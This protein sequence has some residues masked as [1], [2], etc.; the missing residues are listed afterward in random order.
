MT[1]SDPHRRA[2]ISARTHASQRS[3]EP[4]SE[5]YPP[6]PE[7]KF[8]AVESGWSPTVP[9]AALQ[10][11]RQMRLLETLGFSL[12]SYL[13][14]ILLNLAIALPLAWLLN[15]WS[16]EA[17]TLDTSSR[18]IY[19]AIHQA[20]VFEEQAPF[21]FVLLSLWRIIHSSIFFARLFSVLCISLTIYLSFQISRVLFKTIHP[22]W[23]SAAIAFHPYV[24]F[25]AVEIRLYAFSMLLSALL[26]SLF[27]QGYWRHPAQTHARWLYTGIAI[28]ALYTHYFLGFILVA[29]GFILLWHPERTRVR[30]YLWSFGM[31]LLCFAPL[32]WAI[33]QQ[34]VSL[35]DNPATVAGYGDTAHGGMPLL[36]GV[37][38]SFA[39]LL[40]YLI[41]SPHV[42]EASSHLWRILRLMVLATLCWLVWKHRA[43][44]DR[45][46]IAIW[47]VTFIL[48]S[49]LFLTFLKFNSI[50]LRHSGILLLPTLFSI[51]AVLSTLP[52]AWRRRAIAL[53]FSTLFC[54]Y[55]LSLSVTYAPLAKWG[56]YIR[57]AHYLSLHEQPHQPILV[58]NPETEMSLK[59]YYAGVNPLVAL[60]T[61]EDFHSYRWQD[62]T[63]SDP[64]QIEAAIARVGGDREL[65]LVMDTNLLQTIPAYQ[66]SYQIL[67]EF[68]SS[69]YNR[70]SQQDFYGSTVQFL[71]R[72]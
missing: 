14:L 63:L 9:R 54:F 39:A 2:S 50:Q 58:F 46:A 23:I 66:R 10:L 61:A 38:G 52:T 16:D 13:W 33:V 53:L 55:A 60:P 56:D 6:T 71:I 17:Y 18:D 27:W 40:R 11:P 49:L 3:P 35:S 1:P 67:D 20:I 72:K 30:A 32:A 64:Q 36:N 4:G 29:N 22:A 24:I 59:H 51:V 62:L 42:G 47:G 5:P 57:V 37:A 31:V 43:R 15:I 8:T 48:T 7:Q 65:W 25:I 69:H 12:P 44:V 21:Y 45:T 68:I 19:D 26:W 70:I 28:L 41:P 34:I